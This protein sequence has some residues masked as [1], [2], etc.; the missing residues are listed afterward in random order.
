[1]NFFNQNRSKSLG[2]SLEFVFFYWLYYSFFVG[3][4]LW[5]F[6]SSFF[7]NKCSAVNPKW[8]ELVTFLWSELNKITTNL[9]KLT[10]KTTNPKQ[11]LTNSITIN[12]QQLKSIIT[13]GCYYD[14]SEYTKL[15]QQTIFESRIHLNTIAKIW[16][17]SNEI[18][19]QIT[20]NNDWKQQKLGMKNVTQN[21]RI[22]IK[23]SLS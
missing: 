22:T 2:T 10:T 9:T 20:V 15:S 11:N 12:V 23:W 16:L 8:M 6:F 4:F 19:K 5:L 14:A 1:M 3:I 21:Q 13:N 7:S 17:D 18:T